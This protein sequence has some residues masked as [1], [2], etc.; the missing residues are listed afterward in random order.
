MSSHTS[1]PTS[2]HPYLSTCTYA[3]LPVHPHLRTPMCP[4]TPTHPYVSTHTYA[5]LRVHLHLH[6]PSCPPAPTHPYVS[7]RTYAPLRVHLHLHTP[8]SPPAHIPTIMS[9]AKRLLMCLL[10][11][12]VSSL[13]KCLFRSS[14][15]FCDLQEARDFRCSDLAP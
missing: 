11:I 13:A 3:P 7:T 8:P 15:H 9:D 2:G 12:C 5:P 1:M 6:T 10:A 14:A 4:P